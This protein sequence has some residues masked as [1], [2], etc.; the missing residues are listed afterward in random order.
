MKTLIN[1]SDISSYIFCP[2][3]LYLKKVH[4][5]KEPLNEKMILG[6]IKHKILELFSKSEENL[7]S[8]INSIQ[9][10]SSLL[11]LYENSINNL[12]SQ[13]IFLNRNLIRRFNISEKE[14]LN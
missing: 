14:I 7:I 3:K 8:S 10:K 2:R 5:L 9:T 4:G 11:T 6:M 1:I 12:C 13:A